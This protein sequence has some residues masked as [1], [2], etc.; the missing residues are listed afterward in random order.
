[1]ASRPVPAW[2]KVQS[3]ELSAINLILSKLSDTNF[4]GNKEKFLSINVLE[5]PDNLELMELKREDDNSKILPIVRSFIDS[6]AFAKNNDYVSLQLYANMFAELVHNWRGR[7]KIVLFRIMILKLEEEL[8]NFNNTDLPE[9]EDE[10]NKIFRKISNILT[11]LISV[12]VYKNYKAFPVQI[13]IRA[14]HMILKKNEKNLTVLMPCLQ[15]ENFS[16]I[17]CNQVFGKYFKNNLI[18]SLDEWKNDVKSK[19]RFAITD[20]LKTVS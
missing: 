11:F 19:L 3:A 16:Q 1:M 8:I 18:S 2:K 7:Q 13:P 14:L 12:Y 4:E 5:N 9:D 15:S 6:L 10:Q 17:M 20:F